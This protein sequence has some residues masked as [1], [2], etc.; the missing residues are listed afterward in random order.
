[1]DNDIYDE[2]SHLYDLKGDEED[3]LDRYEHDHI[4]LEGLWVKQPKQCLVKW[5]QWKIL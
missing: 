4:I 3:E 5:N 2:N 1:M